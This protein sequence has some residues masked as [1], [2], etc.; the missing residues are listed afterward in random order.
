MENDDNTEK[1]LVLPLNEDSRKIT[2]TLSNEKSLKILELLA[3]QPMS[4]TSIAE[5]LDMPLTT[6][7]YNLD[8]LLE[9]ELIQVKETK[10]SRKGREIKI[11]EPM[12]KMI[13]VVPGSSKTDRSSILG[14]LRKY[15]AMAGAALFAALGIEYLRDFE[16]LG[17]TTPP[18]APAVMS[19]MRL[20]IPAMIRPF[21]L[22]ELPQTQPQKL[23]GQPVNRQVQ[24]MPA[25]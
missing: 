4:A 22:A 21:L 11:Y 10:W 3:R 13:V 14:M 5:E 12:Q 1:V 24:Q 9:S 25:V 19:E 17:Q 15:V 8:G 7:K 2:Q 20:A 6:I 23:P 16:P 18:V